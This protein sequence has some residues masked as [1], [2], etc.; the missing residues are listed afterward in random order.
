MVSGV[1][2]SSGVFEVATLVRHLLYVAPGE[3]NLHDRLLALSRGP[4]RHL[5]ATIGGYYFRYRVTDTED[6]ALKA[7]LAAYGSQHGGRIPPGNV[8]GGS[9]APAYQGLAA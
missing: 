5:P 3:G 9:G 7:V 6:D 1:P 8:M 2:A 4:G